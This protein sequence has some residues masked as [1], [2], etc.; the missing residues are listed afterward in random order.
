[1]SKR[2]IHQQ[3]LSKLRALPS[4]DEIETVAQPRRPA[5]YMGQVGVE[6]KG[7]LKSR[8]EELEAQLASG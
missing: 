7:G 3:V 6:L 4:A 1:M 8:I 5:T 2:D